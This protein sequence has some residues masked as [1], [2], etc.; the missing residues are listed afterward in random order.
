MNIFKKIIYRLFTSG[1]RQGFHVG[2]LASGKSLGDLRVHLHKEWG[3]GGNFSTKIEKG[4]VL[5]WRKLL[6]KKEQYHLRVFEDGEI[7]GHF[8]YTPEAHPLEHLARG[9][10]REASK[11]FLKFLGEYVTRRKFISNLVFDPSAYSPDAEILSE[12]N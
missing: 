3:F 9:G 2:W 1:D 10:K 6:N 12:E 7:R 5:S 8:E 11:E 4:E